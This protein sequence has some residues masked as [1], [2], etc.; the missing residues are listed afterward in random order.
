MKITSLTLQAFRGFN[1]QVTFSLENADIIILYG[2]NGHGK[3]SI[4]DAI[5]WVLTGGIHR[6]NDDSAERKRTRF[7]RNL[8]AETE[9]KSFVRLGIILADARRFT[10]E[11]ECTPT[12]SDRTDYGKH[13]IKIFDENNRLYKENDEA[14][15]LLKKWLIKNEW[16]PKISSATSMLG[17]THILAQEKMA[18][19]LKVMQERDRYDALS[20]LFGTDHFEKYREGFRNARKILNNQL[21]SLKIQ[22]EEKN[23]TRNN[24]HNE[25]QEL[26][27]KIKQNEDQDYNE[28]LKNYFEIFPEIKRLEDDVE[29]LQKAILNNQQTLEFDRKNLINDYTILNEIHKYLPKLVY[30]REVQKAIYNEKQYLQDFKRLSL[31]QKKINLLLNNVDEIIKLNQTMKNS[32]RLRDEAKTKINI[33]TDKRASL[34]SVIEAIDIQ[35]TTSE[36]KEKLDFLSEIKLK[37]EMENFLTIQSLFNEMYKEYKIVEEKKSTQKE[38]QKQLNTIEDLINKINADRQ[39]YNSFL[40]SL[41]HYMSTISEDNIECCPA[42]GTEGIKKEVILLNIQQQQLKIDKDLPA[43]EDIRL[44]TEQNLKKINSDIDTANKSISNLQNKIQDTLNQL[45]NELKSIN[46]TITTENQKQLNLQQEIDSIKNNINRFEEDCKKIGV[47]N[48]INIKLE[49]EKKCL[50][51]TANIEELLS[52]R[53]MKSNFEYLPEEVRN[54][55]IDITKFEDNENLLQQALENNEYEIRRIIR[56]PESLQTIVIDIKEGDL[57]EQK[58]KVDKLIGDFKGEIDKHNIIERTNLK[59]LGMIEYNLEKRHLFK[60]QHQLKELTNELELLDRRRMK[61]EENSNYL[62]ILVNKSTEAV[63]NL[64]EE[65]FLNLKDTIQTIFGHINSHPIFT[66]LDLVLD[67]RYN[68]NCLTIN[69][70][71]ANEEDEVK[72]NA[73][74]VFSSAQVNSVALSLFLAMSLKQQWSSLQLVGMDDPIQSMDEIN[75]ISFIDLLRLFVQ[76][77]QKQII[78]STHDY[79]FYKLML[80]KFRYHNLAIIEYSTYGIQGPTFAESKDDTDTNKSLIRA[81]MDYVQDLERLKLLDEKGNLDDVE[82]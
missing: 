75:V 71:N 11:R 70:S 49:L 59:L 42:C 19:F 73:P 4:Y 38:Q 35:I 67:R 41:N 44:L 12:A 63:S 24:L 17:L 56:L 16:I 40:S 8:H 26:I 5:E 37:V 77:H 14:E 72:A 30:L 52:T 22:I 25:V 57:K 23:K 2:P 61:M 60:L 47:N 20:I 64:N 3:S 33:L 53:S 58:N 36:W 29:K 15:A 34:L 45:N 55:K 13:I 69:V 81:K 82:Y 39:V 68:N 31:L 62:T 65:V 48:D 1:N 80:K 9:V 76:K 78:I 79:G 46:I 18:A 66:K 54:K 28:E 32:F 10:I 51:I 43:L 74:Y 7:I 6:F 21:E 27:I 50:E